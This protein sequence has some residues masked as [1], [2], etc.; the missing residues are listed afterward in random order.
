VGDELDLRGAAPLLA[1]LDRLARI[2]PGQEDLRR[3]GAAAAAAVREELGLAHV[4]IAMVDAERGVA[5]HLAES[6]LLAEP[7]PAGYEQPLTRGVLGRC[8]R[9]GKTQY[10][11]DVS[12]D[13]DYLA[14]LPGVT[15]ELVVPLVVGDRLIGLM[16]CEATEP[17]S[18]RTRITLLELVA[19]RLAVTLDMALLVRAQRERAAELALINE[20]ARAASGGLELRP[21]LQRIVDAMRAAFGWEF[22][23]CIR[24]DR[25]GERFVCDALST[26]LP[27]AVYVGY[28][29]PFGSGVVGEVAATATPI[30]IDDV[31][32]WPNYVETLPGARSEL[33]VPAI[34]RGEVVALL[35]L[36]SPRLAAFHDQ[37]PLLSTIADQVAGAIASARLFHEV[38]R[39]AG[40]LA[41]LSE[42]S[43]TAM[44][45]SDLQ[46]LL[47]AVVAFV[48]RRLG[49]PMVALVL[50]DGRELELVAHAGSM[51][52]LVSRGARMPIARGIVGRAARTGDVQLV[53]DVH[54]DA[55]YDT[56]NADVR[57]ELA[58]PIRFG[59]EILG[60]L[61]LESPTPAL[62]NEETQQ[63][64]TTLADQVAGAVRMARVN[65]RLGDTNRML[66]DLFSRY[67]APDLVQVL[68]TDPERFQ[69]Q[70]ERRDVSVL[71][72]DIRGFTGLTQR[73]DSQR[74]L[75]LLNQFYSA[76]GEAI[77][78]HRGSINRILGDGL[79]AVFGVPERLDGHAAAAVHAALDMQRA[80]D[81]LSPRWQVEAG[82]PLDVAMSI[83][84]G[85]VVVGSI[86]DPRHL[87]FTVLGDV[88]NVAARLETEA[89][90]RGA[91]LLVTDDVLNAVHDVPAEA[92]GAIELRGRQG[93][94]GIHRVL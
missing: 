74:V 42:V 63:V 27:T 45:S 79:M 88:V 62:L 85:E 76:M 30:L 58:V 87:A 17:R 93:R 25:T 22:V 9:E 43:R 94:V 40:H 32:T 21:T 4:A 2:E 19:G 56:I 89:K 64:A 59:D 68:L 26:D 66:A 77:F 53:L 47:D 23:A 36:E 44:E 13:P 5:A 24:V 83:N 6:T 70:G 12:R 86:G 65:Q 29:R 16:D 73:L 11:E 48:H 33:C 20:V 31:S 35:N 80:V 90:N 7:V 37:L 46:S 82:T 67:V 39:R 91:R 51:P 60:V 15:T 52:L 18:L 61:N 1:A 72:A 3:I 10:V 54:S 14:V 34:Y 50:I 41:M 49:V 84:C 38:R 28:S 71:F 78:G 69:N 57:A 81:E 75:G 92:L 55:D 8:A